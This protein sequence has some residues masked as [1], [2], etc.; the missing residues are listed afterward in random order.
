MW[1]HGRDLLKLFDHPIS[2][3]S[4]V[5]QNEFALAA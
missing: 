3:N 2:A 5:K 4:D 1:S